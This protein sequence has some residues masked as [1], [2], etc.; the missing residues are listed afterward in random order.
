M[1]ECS[2]LCLATAAADDAEGLLADPTVLA[3]I[4]Y[5]EAA[6]FTTP[7][8][9]VAFDA[10]DIRIP[11]HPLTASTALE[12]WRGTEPV[13]QYQHGAVILA[14]TSCLSIGQIHL[15]ETAFS[16]LEAASEY[17]YQQILQAL[18]AGPHPYLLRLWNYFPAINGRAGEL[19]RYQ[20]F[21]IGRGRAIDGAAHW[22]TPA[23][24]AIGSHAAGLLIYFLAAAQPG[25][26]IENP[27]QVAADRYPARY[28]PRQPSF[29]RA[30]AKSWPSST[31]LYISGT[32]SI[33]G[34][35]TRH[36]DVITQLKEALRNFTALV[37]RAQAEQQ[38]P[39]P[40]LTLLKAYVRY[41]E[42]METVHDYLAQHLQPALPFWVLCG[43]ICRTDLLV[44][45][46][47]LYAEPFGALA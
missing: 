15:D 31:H 39:L 23:A 46:E 34:H 32:A 24:T 13:K 26:R 41:P 6:S 5:G 29:A 40:P 36:D 21:C 9:P 4:R 1:A 44:E 3:V 12:V 22:P 8:T 20:A 43:D 27:R 47:G 2:P 42:Q 19:E 35:E 18:A 17:A 28:G 37:D 10:R 33:V 11:L 45:I 7:S 14:T 16:D 25:R 30:T 38:T